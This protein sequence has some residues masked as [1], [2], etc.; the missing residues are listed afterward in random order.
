MFC[1]ENK[2]IYPVYLS[3]QKF[4]NCMDLLLI[5]DECKSHYMCIKDLDI[6]IFNKTRNKNKKDFFR[7]CLQCFS[8]E[9]VL[10]E[11][12]KDCLVVNG[13]QNVKLKTGL[14]SFK[15]Y[16]K[17]I[18][19]SFKIYTDIECIFKNIECN[20]IECYNSSYTKKYQDHIPC[21]FAYK[22]V[23]VNNKFSKKVKLYRGKDAVKRFIKSILSEYNYC[24]KVARNSLI[25]NLIMSAKEEERFELSNMCWICNKLFDEGDN[26]VRDHCHVIGK[27]RGAAHW[28]C[29]VNLKMSKKVPVPFHNLKGYDSHL[30]FK[31]LSRFDLK[32]S[33]IPNRLEKYMVFTINRNLIFID[34][35]QF[36]NSS[37]DSLVKNLG[38]KDFKYLSEEFSG[39]YLRLV[40]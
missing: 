1:Y 36:M 21:S 31:E 30:I 17:Q 11:H 14:I 20:S 3:D 33:V 24:K 40:K 38:D 19:V 32:I 26:K 27:Y 12:R 35:M 15:N 8:N 10:I 34:S 7:C 23:C 5:S 13:K 6:F 39:E 16:F 4:E 28:S 37:L 22:V 2:V 29:N 25:E 9:K 18:P